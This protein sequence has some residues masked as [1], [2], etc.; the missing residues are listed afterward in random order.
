MLRATDS[1]S[2][3]LPAHYRWQLQ[4]QLVATKAEVACI[5]L[6]DGNKG[7]LFPVAPEPSAWP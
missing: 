4:R 2:R 5:F 6:F 3:Q 1:E 7:I